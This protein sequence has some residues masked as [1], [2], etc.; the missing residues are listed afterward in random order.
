VFGD[1]AQ[2]VD[3]A[4]VITMPCE[5]ARGFMIGGRGTRQMGFEKG[6]YPGQRLRADEFID[7]AAIAEQLHR[8]NAADLELLRQVLVLVGV[9]LDDLDLAIGLSGH[10]FQHGSQRTA[11]TAPGGPEIHEHGQLAGGVEDLGGEV[12]RTDGGHGCIH[13]PGYGDAK[14]LIQ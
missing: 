14:R 7:H 3:R 11:G 12:G 8:G 2:L 5:L 10:L 4:G 13:A 9:H 1:Q 6:A